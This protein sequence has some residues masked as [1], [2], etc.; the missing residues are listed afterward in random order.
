MP[1]HHM[2]ALP[3]ALSTILYHCQP[4]NGPILVFVLV[5]A[6]GYNV[7][8]SDGSGVFWVNAPAPEGVC[9][10][11]APDDRYTCQQQVSD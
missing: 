3:Y 5:L 8:A 6:D 7:T 4:I 11:L 1:P 2:L 10:D 9:S